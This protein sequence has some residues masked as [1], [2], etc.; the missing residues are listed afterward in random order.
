L[1][2]VEGCA[3]KRTVVLILI[4]AAV[5]VLTLSCGSQSIDVRELAMVRVTGADGFASLFAG[6]DKARID[7][8]LEQ[9]SA[10]LEESDEKGFQRLFQREAVLSSLVFTPDKRAGLKNGDEV[11]IRIDYDRQLAKEAGLRFRNVRFKYKVE[12]L[13]EAVPIPIE[14]GVDLAFSGYD[15]QGRCSQVLSGDVDRFRQGFEFVFTQ[16]SANLSNGDWVELK[17]IPDNLFLTSKG[18]IAR[19]TTLSFEVKGLPPMTEIDLFEDLVLIFDGVSDQGI[20]SFDTTRLPADWVEGGPQEETPVRFTAVPSRGLSNGELVRV[21]AMVDAG[22]FAERGLKVEATTREYRVSGLKE[23]P[24]NLDGVDLMPLFKKIAPW[25]EKDMTSRLDMN[26]WND[27]FKTGEPVSSWDYDHLTGV[28]RIFYGYNQANRARNFV[29]IL[30]KTAV[31]GV[32]LDTV[33][34]QS[35]YERG[36]QVESTLYL[37]YLIDEIM[38]DRPD[39]EDFREIKLVMHGDAELDV[40]TEFKNR[41]GGDHVLIVDVA[42]PDQVVSGDAVSL[43]TP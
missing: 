4:L 37:L 29:A 19:E 11:L 31:S 6:T 9:E 20:L 25:L 8:W 10:R 43:P 38:Y 27:D 1:A 42:V 23:Y 35:F 15:G 40:I 39:V 5:L 12:G 34:Y 21:E 22:W 13:E 17:V 2:E 26:Y 16:G 3:L 30:Y 33:P 28:T 32:C 36:D 7:F 41:Y 24:R 18:R 14:Q